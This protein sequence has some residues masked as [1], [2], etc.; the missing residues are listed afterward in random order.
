MLSQIKDPELLAQLKRLRNL[1]QMLASPSR[2]E[3][4]IKSR[5]NVVKSLE[6][7]VGGQLAKISA[8]YIQSR[9][10]FTMKPTEVGKRLRIGEVLLDYI[11]YDKYL[12]IDET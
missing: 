9:R 4:A 12:D 1:K 10:A 5:M 7:T 2:D 6:D 8:K 3:D 11:R